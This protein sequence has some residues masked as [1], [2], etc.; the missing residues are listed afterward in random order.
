VDA[1]KNQLAALVI[2]KQSEESAFFSAFEK[3]DSSDYRLGKTSDSV[4]FSRVSTA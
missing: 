1:S 4:R 3:A 2:P